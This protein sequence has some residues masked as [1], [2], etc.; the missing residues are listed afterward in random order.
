MDIGTG[1]AIFGGKD[2]FLKIAGP[3]A[4]YLGDEILTF[5]KKRISNLNNIVHRAHKL[6]GEEIHKNG[7][8][9]PKVLKD[10]IDVGT[11][12]SDPISVE[13]YGGLLAASRTGISRDDR[14]VPILDIVKSLS[15]YQIRTHYIIYKIIRTC[16]SDSGLKVT[17]NADKL[18]IFIPF[19]VYIAAMSFEVG[20]N[21]DL[22]TSHSIFGL[23]QKGL[24]SP[25]FRY[26]PIEF[27]HEGLTEIKRKTIT[28]P[29]IIVAASTLGAET[30]MFANSQSN[31]AIND[32]IS[33]A[34]II[35]DSPEVTINAG[36]LKF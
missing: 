15:T 11:M 18:K 23:F 26:G 34:I 1:L 28:S 24:I 4:D 29:G 8:V 3:T 36:A 32:F 16:F 33:S 21:L 14:T 25:G 13:Y 20:E 31:C 9:P 2:I 6:L 12:N 10:I 30:F 5:A 19:D 35:D 22:V 7:S 27:L 17:N